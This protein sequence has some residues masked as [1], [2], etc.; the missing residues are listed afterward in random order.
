MRGLFLIVALLTSLSGCGTP[1]PTVETTAKTRA[2]TTT[3][4][5]PEAKEI[6]DKVAPMPREVKP[7][8]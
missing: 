1:V 2:Q 6:Y 4:V 8:P 5:H 7:A 3:D